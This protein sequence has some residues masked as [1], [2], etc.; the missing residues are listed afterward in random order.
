[1]PTVLTP[2]ARNGIFRYY[3]NWANGNALQA[4][5]TGS[6]PRIAVVDHFGNPVAPTTN[7]DGTPHNGILRYASVFGRLQNTP[8]RPDCSDAVVTGPAWDS[9]R[10]KSGHDG[11]HHETARRDAASQ[12]RRRRRRPEYGGSRWLQTLRGSDNR[13]SIGAAN[14]RKQINVKIDHNFSARQKINAGWSFE[15]AHNERSGVWPFNFH[16]YSFRQPQVL[17]VNFT[18]TLSPTCSTKPSSDSGRPARTRRLPFRHPTRGKEALD[19]Y[20]NVNGIP[21]VGSWAF[22]RRARSASAADNL[23]R[24]RCPRSF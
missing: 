1:M 21:F 18:S 10:N 4:I 14:I 8:T 19:W 11:I 12:Q 17:T 6:T 24:P 15:R 23:S 13:F 3:D 7:P 22:C 9:N 5:N 16:S 20:P 2:C